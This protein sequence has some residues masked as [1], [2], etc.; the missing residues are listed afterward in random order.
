V[1]PADGA[2]PAKGGPEGRRSLKINKINRIEIIIKEKFNGLLNYANFLPK[3]LQWHFKEWRDATG[4]AEVETLL[5]F[6]ETV[7]ASAKRRPILVHCR[8]I[9]FKNHFHQPN[10]T[11]L[12]VL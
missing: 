1:A 2:A 9:T 5:T 6:I 12:R 10:L 8:Q 11:V 3:V 4:P 7:R